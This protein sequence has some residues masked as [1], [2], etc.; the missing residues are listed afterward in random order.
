MFDIKHQPPP[1][2]AEW[3]KLGEALHD[4]RVEL[5]LQQTEIAGR[6]GPSSAVVRYAEHGDGGPYRGVTIRGYEAALDWKAG[7][8][9][10][11]LN[12][13]EATVMEKPESIMDMAAADG[14]FAELLLQRMTQLEN[15]VSEGWAS[16]HPPRHLELAEA[17]YRR[18]TGFAR[19]QG[20]SVER[21]I[22]MLID[23]HSQTAQR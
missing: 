18:L 8:F 1:G 23:E 6:G 11:I 19:D 17:T 20:L 9:M 3:K 5:G 15:M 12:G 21:A 10:A 2:A 16:Q 13:G 14:T 22:E 4:R 7:S